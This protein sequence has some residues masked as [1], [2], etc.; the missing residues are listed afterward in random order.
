MSKPIRFKN[1]R[2][3]RCTAPACQYQ[4]GESEE[5]NFLRIRILNSG[6]YSRSAF[7][8]AVLCGPCFNEALELLSSCKHD[9]GPKTQTAEVFVDQ[10]EKRDRRP[11]YFI[12][13]ACFARLK[14]RLEKF[15][16]PWSQFV[17]FLKF[18]FEGS[19]SVVS[20]KERSN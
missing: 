3:T 17:E 10:T 11:N 5:N 4:F 2:I 14:T 7:W 20:K 16:L 1:A 6:L 8:G 13:P 18:S 12:C 15:L 19:E 9:F